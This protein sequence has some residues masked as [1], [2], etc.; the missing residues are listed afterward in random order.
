MK[1]ISVF[2]VIAGLLSMFAGCVVSQE[3]PP[4]QGR[5]DYY[6]GNS[7]HERI[8]S[9]QRSIEH[10]IRSGELNKHEAEIVQ[11]NLDHIKNKYAKMK[12]D[13]MLTPKE[14]EKLDKMLEEN[15]NMI[16]NKKHN[17]KY[18]IRRVY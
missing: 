5:G 3:R 7:F 2:F 8:N 10:G 4:Y 1:R 11:D 18:D 6:E 13:G 15:S 14:L 17:R 9:Q 16:Y 12:A